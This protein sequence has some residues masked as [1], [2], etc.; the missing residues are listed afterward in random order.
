MTMNTAMKDGLTDYVDRFNYAAPTFPTTKDFN[1][2]SIS[3]STLKWK[4]DTICKIIKAHSINT[5]HRISIVL[6]L[7]KAD[8]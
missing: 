7:Q 1:T 8:G 6:S 4:Q 3:E 5:Q 2:N